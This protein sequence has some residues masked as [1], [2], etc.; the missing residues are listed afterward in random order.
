MGDVVYMKEQLA[1]KLEEGYDCIKIKV[2][3]LDFDKEVK[4]IQEIRKQYSAN[5]IEIRVD[6]NGAFSFIQA[7]D[8]LT[9]LSQ[10]EIHSIE[11]PIKAGQW[12]N[13]AE[14]CKKNTLANCARRGVDRN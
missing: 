1:R 7:M 2:G 12:D 14:L 4:L 13:M 3:A 10:F 9:V 5:Q 6:A 11:Q 8:R